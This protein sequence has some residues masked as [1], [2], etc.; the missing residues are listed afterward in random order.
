MTA[1]RALPKMPELGHPESYYAHRVHDADRHGNAHAHEAHK[2]GQYITL[3]MNPVLSWETKMKYFGHALK[4]HCVPPP[5]P[6]EEIWMFYRDLANLVREN[7]GREALR[8]AS[9][10]DDL[11][12]ARLAMGQTKEKIE[13][14]AEVFFGR[15][16][17]SDPCPPWF[18]EGDW[19]QLKLIR[20][21]WI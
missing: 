9:L 5:L 2:V 18:N 3:A 21:Q 16:I 4:R 14:E 15:L 7:A 6:D 20:D 10:E 11:Y 12:A 19:Q 17:E 13:D 8:L 1:Q